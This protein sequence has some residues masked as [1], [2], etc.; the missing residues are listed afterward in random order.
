MK[1]LL[2][3][4][5]LPIL[6]HGQA[7]KLSNELYGFRLGQYK[8][9]VTNELG[10]PD[11][12]RLFEDSTRIDF[13][14]IS[15]DSSSYIGVQYLPSKPKE[16]YAL[17]LSGTNKVERPFYG[18]HLQDSKEKLVPVFGKPDSIISQDFNDR[19][20]E[21]W[22]YDNSRLSVLFVENKIESIRIWDDY[23]QKGYQYP[24]IE[25]LLAIISTYD[26]SKIADILSPGLE[27]YSCDDIITWKNS[28]YRDIYENKSSVFNFILNPEFGLASLLNKKNLM[29][30]DNL[31]FI[32]GFGSFPVFKFMDDPLLMEVVL[33]YE[34]G[35]Y[36]I[37]EIKYRCEK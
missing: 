15:A 2:L 18:L 32:A 24:S 13:Y 36:K 11:G 7:H 30:E 14:Y 35:S 22:R 5:L 21:T 27:V 12:T 31:R 20:A 3:F 17:Q 33:N 34:Q 10:E 1:N 37:W 9:V 16:I 28:F 29:H 6:C 25:E 19:A 26:T 23:D 8:A 4:L